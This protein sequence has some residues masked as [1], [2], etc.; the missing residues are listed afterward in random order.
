[1][2]RLPAVVFGV[3]VAA[4]VGAFFLTQHL[5]SANPYINGLP[6]PDPPAIN[7]A[8]G[9]VCRNLIGKRVS[10]RRT[11]V[12]FYLQ[13]HAQVVDVLVFNADDEQVA[14]ASGSGRYVRPGAKRYVFYSWDG[15]T[16][17]GRVA[18]DGTYY[19]RVV[20]RSEGVPIPINQPIQVI[21]RPPRPLVSSVR[22]TGSS[23]R[24]PATTPIIS[25]SAP[26][27]TVTI[28]FT[29][30]DYRDTRI[31]ILRTD[32]PGPPRQV[33]AFGAN[34]R[35][36]VAAW[37]GRINGTPAPAGTYLVGLRVTDP[38]CNVGS[39]PIISNP[40]P[41]STPH[42]GVTVRY[43]AA[44]PPLAPTTAGSKAT[45]FVDSRLEPYAWTLRAV[46][47]RKVLERG[48][49]SFATVRAGRAIALPV[50][51]PPRGAAIYQLALRSG[52]HV[53]S[54]PLVAAAG[55]RRAAARV[56]VV[57]PA[58][59]WQGNN[60]VDDSGDGL[61]DTLVAGDQIDLE[62]PLV[63][64]LPA[65]LANEQGLLA[66]LTSQHAAYQ[67][68]TDVALADGVGPQLAGHTGVILDGTFT[69]LPSPLATRLRAFANAGGTIV[70]AGGGSLRRLAPL[71]TDAG[72]PTAGPP[73]GVL[74]TDP[75]GARRGSFNPQPGQLMTVLTDQL[76]IFG[77]T[78]A[79]AGL[80]S[81]ETIQ[82][83]AGAAASLAGVADGYPSIA[84]FRLGRGT[85]VEIGV[86]NFGAA[87][88]HNVDAQELVGRL[89]QLASRHQ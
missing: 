67:L 59:T 41:G 46:G 53:T 11:R 76:G 33:F 25:G 22:V 16:S 5:K 51:L 32:L 9:V 18:P 15:R 49:A 3:L 2:S 68:T 52:S 81:N 7:P 75:F 44:E 62:R 45:V 61:P 34:G 72:R 55:G 77:S 63:A 42:A 60:P 13:T 23:P 4:T 6:R 88:A 82:P 47:A 64:G 79:F 69:W 87:L 50:K 26:D 38:A 39:F 84:G 30:G 83:P 24:A 31:R 86:G 58:L 14:I 21:T 73:S 37:N 29:P 8:A 80:H 66:Y 71:A 48:A 56:L 27:Q 36:G 20:L 28:H 12:G 89:W 19:F 10:F 17:D 54:V 85:V 40:P 74:A 57:L 43:L 1:V 35:L 78:V 70:A 65:D